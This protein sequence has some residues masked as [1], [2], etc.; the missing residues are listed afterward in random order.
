MK[1]FIFIVSAILLSADMECMAINGYATD[2]L[3]EMAMA[4]NVTPRLDTL[5][6]GLYYR[7]FTYNGRP[8]TVEVQQG[9][10][11]HI[12][13]S[14][15]S[16]TQRQVLKSP[17]CNFLERYSLE[18]TLPLQRQ[19]SLYRQLEENDIR[20]LHGS[21]DT[22]KQIEQDTS[23]SV[24][25]KSLNDK[26]YAV[27]WSKGENEIL[28]VTFPISHELL[29]GCNM[30]ESERRLI[31]DILNTAASGRLFGSSL[32]VATF[33]P[34]W[35][36]KYYVVKGGEFYLPQLNCDKYY[37]EVKDGE[38]TSYQL[39]YNPAF[40]AESL[41]NLFTTSEIPNDYIVELRIRKYGLKED[42]IKVPLN[43][44]TA[45]CLR[46]DCV[47]YFGIVKKEKDVTCEIIMHNKAM[48]YA[49]VMCA[50]IDSESMEDRKSVIKARVVPYVPTARIK[51]LFDELKL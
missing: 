29:T 25:I 14:L 11:M 38:N 20:F 23:Y 30:L 19:K 22:F 33:H 9:N 31:D 2:L 15:F 39:L 47:P 44:W 28:V 49:H 43:K 36:G 32:D 37:V 41:S 6:N 24:V 42:T 10:V 8:L 17:A 1:R 4:M 13:Y 18:I 3:G 40:M 7:D 5:S 45:F 27:S 35:Q 16:K 21:F 12:G 50:V 48:G 51:Y 26:R 46:R 34:L